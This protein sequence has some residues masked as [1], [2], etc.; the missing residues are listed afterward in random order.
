MAHP[1]VWIDMVSRVVYSPTGHITAV[2][3]AWT[4][5]DFYSVAAVDGLDLNK[6]GTFDPPELQELADTYL[7]NLK[8]YGYFTAVEI[9]GKKV[10]TGTA[11]AGRAV[12]TKGLL[13]FSFELPLSKPVDPKVSTFSYSSFDPS[14]Y[15]DISPAKSNPVFFDG[16]APKGCGYAMR[17]TDA[18]PPKPEAL[19]MTQ[20]LLSQP[21]TDGIFGALSVAIVDVKCK[22]GPIPGG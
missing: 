5:D 22:A 17:K 9:G 14:F 18:E 21:A 7:K 3:I 8:S 12:V 11:R 19:N 16:P 6:N 2:R 13:T 4:F 1:H 15:I 20:S 10:E